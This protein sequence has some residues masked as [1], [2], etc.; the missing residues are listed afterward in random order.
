MK[1]KDIKPDKENLNTSGKKVCLCRYGIP[2]EKKNK[3][4]GGDIE[5]YFV[6]Q[7][8][9]VITPSEKKI[10]SNN[11]KKQNKKY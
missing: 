4:K 9:K 11:R 6:K 7:K 5:K 2:C 8:K 3:E 1:I 10:F